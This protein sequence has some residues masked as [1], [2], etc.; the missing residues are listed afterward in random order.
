M[1]ETLSAESFGRLLHES[2]N[3]WHGAPEDVDW[4][5]LTATTRTMHVSVARRV[6]ARYDVV[7]K[8][9]RQATFPL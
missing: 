7:P 2:F 5:D 1:S 8:A 4:T 6:L 9:S 3:E